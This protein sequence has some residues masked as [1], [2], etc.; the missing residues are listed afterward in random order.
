MN[1]KE[2]FFLVSNKSQ[3]NGHMPR[4]ETSLLLLL[5]KISWLCLF[6]LYTK[7]IIILDKYWMR[8]QIDLLEKYTSL[9]QSLLTISPSMMQPPVWLFHFMW[10]FKKIKLYKT[11]RILYLCKIMYMLFIWCNTWQ[12]LKRGY[13][14]FI[15]KYIGN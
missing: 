4:K 11:E 9:K 13:F 5:K 15:H 8:R 2:L 14:M 6:S 7:L 3:W 1:C 12:Q 10:H